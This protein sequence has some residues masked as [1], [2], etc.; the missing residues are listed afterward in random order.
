M[1]AISFT[2]AKVLPFDSYVGLPEDVVLSLVGGELEVQR[3]PLRRIAF[4][5]Y[6]EF[7]GQ[8]GLLSFDASP[9]LHAGGHSIGTNGRWSSQQKV[10]GDDTNAIADEGAVPFAAAEFARSLQ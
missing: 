2:S 5:M 10:S 9:R 4:K 7:S 8:R 1:S 6:F 3:S